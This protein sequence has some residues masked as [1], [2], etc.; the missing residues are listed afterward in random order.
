MRAEPAWLAGVV[1]RPAGAR[2]PARAAEGLARAGIPI[3]DYPD[4]THSLRCQYPVPD[5][6]VAYSLTEGREVINPRPR[7][8]AAIFHA[9]ADQTIGFITYSEGCNDDVNK[10]VWSALGWD[11]QADVLDVLRHYSRYFIGLDRSRSRRLRPRA[12]GPGTELAWAALDQ[13]L[14]RDDAPA[15]PGPGTPGVAPGAGRTGGSS[16]RSTA[17]ITMPTCAAA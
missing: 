12:L 15:V 6:D 3:R 10:I 4:I 2:E 8:E 17:P 16:R 14:G 11:P 1:Y 7:D 9:F 13:S 5:W